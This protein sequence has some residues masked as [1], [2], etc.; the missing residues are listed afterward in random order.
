MGDVE[1]SNANCNA[2][3][4]SNCYVSAFLADFEEKILHFLSPMW[5]EAV[6]EW[7]NYYS[8]DNRIHNYSR[9]F[10]NQ[11]QFSSNGWMSSRLPNNKNAHPMKIVTVE[12]WARNIFHHS[13]RTHRVAILAPFRCKSTDFGLAWYVIRESRCISYSYKRLDTIVAGM[14]RRQLLPRACLPSPTAGFWSN[15]L[16]QNDN[17]FVIVIFLFAV[18][19]Y[20]GCAVLLMHMQQ[21]LWTIVN[22]IYVRV[23]S[24]QVQTPTNII[25]Y[26]RCRNANENSSNQRKFIS[27]QFVRTDESP[28]SAADALP[29]SAATTKPTKCTDYI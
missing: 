10:H 2:F 12:M 4:Q 8:S 14:R 7:Q 15:V 11:F 26:Y 28:F 24:I 1:G 16:A 25:Y 23:F 3:K 17:S 9:S 27:F 29:P 13:S 6:A 19:S 20:Y 18:G 5:N 22:A 21:Y